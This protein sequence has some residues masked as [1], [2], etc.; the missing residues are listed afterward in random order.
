MKIIEALLLDVGFYLFVYC[1][2][3]TWNR[4]IQ[5]KSIQSIKEI[6]LMA[7]AIFFIF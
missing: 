4:D 2:L 7:E 3:S 6:G 5:F 1:Y